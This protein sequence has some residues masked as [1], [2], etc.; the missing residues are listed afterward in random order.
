VKEREREEEREREKE[1]ERE[2]ET[3]RERER[4]RGRYCNVRGDSGGG[5]S[6]R[7]K[8]AA[9]CLALE[10][11]LL[12]SRPIAILTDSK[13]LMTFGSNCVGEGKEPLP[14]PSPDGDILG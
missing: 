12:H 10:D 8:F 4:E 11:S 2:R 7:A 9:A 14:R 6:G 13:G 3:E 5:S 1:R